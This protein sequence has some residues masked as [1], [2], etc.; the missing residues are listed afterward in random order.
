MARQALEHAAQGRSL[1]DHPAA[2]RKLVDVLRPLESVQA[3]EQDDTIELACQAVNLYQ[4]GQVSTLKQGVDWVSSQGPTPFARRQA[5]LQL[6]E[7]LEKLREQ[8]TVFGAKGADGEQVP[9]AI[10][11]SASAFCSLQ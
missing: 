8:P 4:L 5:A 9:G 7:S 1:F 6:A 10:E 11:V 2:E 3:S